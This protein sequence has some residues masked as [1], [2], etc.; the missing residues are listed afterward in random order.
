MILNPGTII[1]SIDVATDVLSDSGIENARREAYLL[2]QY[3]TSISI[4]QLRVKPNIVLSD[5]QWNKIWTLINRRAKYEPFAYLVNMKEFWSLPFEVTKNTLIPRPDSETL[6]ETMLDHI[7]NK[8]A[9]LKILDLGTGCGCLLGA[10]LKEFQYSSGLGIDAN[11]AV[12]NIA[13]QNMKQ[14]GFATRTKI[15]TGNWGDGIRDSFD[16]IICNPPYI[17]TGEIDKLE[18]GVKNYEPR[19]ALD[20]G[21]DGLESYR[22]IAGHI[23]GLLNNNGAAVVEFGYGQGTAVANIFETNGLRIRTFGRDLTSKK[24]CLLATL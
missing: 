12:S 16:A 8:N 9:R 11:L 23:Y 5:A 10:L 7:P 19:I 17:P 4:T 21:K 14:L 3:A 24:R 6:I 2:F 13:F 1:K 20:G 22:I 18:I 15:I